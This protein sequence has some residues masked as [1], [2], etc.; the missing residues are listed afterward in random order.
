MGKKKSS[1]TQILF[2]CFVMS[3][4]VFICLLLSKKDAK[5]PIQ[6]YFSSFSKK[7]RKS[8]ISKFA[9]DKLE[10]RYKEKRHK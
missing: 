4:F 7:K 2:F 1:P 5:A 3:Y 8:L 9:F 6:I 10:E